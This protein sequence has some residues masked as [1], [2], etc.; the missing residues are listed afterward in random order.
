[1]LLW[2]FEFWNDDG[3]VSKIP[4]L[5]IAMTPGVIVTRVASDTSGALRQNITKQIFAQPKAFLIANVMVLLIMII[6]GFQKIPFVILGVALFFRGK[7]LSKPART[8][9]STVSRAGTGLPS[10]ASPKTSQVKQDDGEF[11]VTVSLL[12]DVTT[13]IEQSVEPDILNDQLIQVRQAL[14]YDLSVPFSGIH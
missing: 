14:Y 9:A 4:A 3:L 10:D 6:P 12:L 8:S 11:S 2:C 7:R 5:L 13:V 1:L